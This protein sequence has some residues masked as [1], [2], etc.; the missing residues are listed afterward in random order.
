MVLIIILLMVALLLLGAAF[1]YFTGM[2]DSRTPSGKTLRIL[3]LGSGL[4]IIGAAGVS[5]AIKVQENTGIDT[6]LSGGLESDA[7][8]WVSRHRADPPAPNQ[9][10]DNIRILREGLEFIRKHP[11]VGA[12]PEAQSISQRYGILPER[13][14]RLLTRQEET[15]FYEGA[16]AVYELISNV[17]TGN[18]AN[19]AG[20]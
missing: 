8:Q 17:A 7:R 9:P 3:L 18:V 11:S 10:G 12:S 14:T 19:T 5:T 13:P 2:P 16:K 4:F 15:E 6:G 20:E 1:F